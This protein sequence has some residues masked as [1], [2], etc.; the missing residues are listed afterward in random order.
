MQR[1]SAVQKQYRSGKRAGTE[2]NKDKRI[3]IEVPIFCKKWLGGSGIA[4]CIIGI[5]QFLSLGD[6]DFLKRKN[7]WTLNHVPW[8]SDNTFHF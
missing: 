6:A 5:I 7:V 1:L 4:G 8:P 3:V 2:R